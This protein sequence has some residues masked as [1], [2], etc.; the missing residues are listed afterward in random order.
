MT[1]RRIR[2]LLFSF[3]FFGLCFGTA[4]SAYAQTRSLDDGPAVRRQLLH[5]SARFE[6]QPG[7]ATMWGNSYTT[8]FYGNLA[9]RYNLSN[10]VSVGLDLNGSPFSLDRGI[11][12]DIEE[13]DPSVHAIYEVAKTPF[14]G[15]FQ[16][17]YSP[18]I[19]KVNIFG[20]TT[21][22]FDVHLIAGVGV[23]MRT[24]DSPALRGTSVAPVIGIGL[25]IFLTDG[26]ALVGRVVDYIYQDVEAYR[27]GTSVDEK[28]RN[29]VVGTIGVSFFFPRGV[30]VSR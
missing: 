11:V 18:A 15:S 16:V 7:I 22:Y 20:K 1:P 8:P 3:V 29:H 24:A 19:G 26:I 27:V 14:I 23:A 21:T 9:L 30:Y 5:R 4:I 6:L 25:R 10:S 17:T 12:S 13:N 28:W 2:I